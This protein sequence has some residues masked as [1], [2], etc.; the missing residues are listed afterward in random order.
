MPQL[1][2]GQKQSTNMAEPEEIEAENYS[3]IHKKDVKHLLLSVEQDMPNSLNKYPV[4]ISTGRHRVAASPMEAS[5]LLGTNKGSG[6]RLTLVSV[7]WTSSLKQRMSETWK[8]GQKRSKSGAPGK[9][10]SCCI[11]PGLTRSTKLTPPGGNTG[12]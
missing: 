5:H 12:N 3:S 1:Q 8:I 4:S 6:E 9:I 11:L 10:R 2:P 7:L